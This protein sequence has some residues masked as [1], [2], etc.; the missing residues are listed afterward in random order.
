MLKDQI[1]QKKNALG[2]K[3]PFR[4][5][6]AENVQQSAPTGRLSRTQTAQAKGGL[7]I[8][9]LLPAINAR[10]LDASS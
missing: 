8:S 9:A 1:P 7:K 10:L 5:A 2:T 3:R 6:G 4:P